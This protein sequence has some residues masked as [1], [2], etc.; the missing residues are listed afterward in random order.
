MWVVSPGSPYLVV[1]RT[2]IFAVALHRKVNGEKALLPI[3]NAEVNNM[4]FGATFP[5]ISVLFA[6]LFP[7]NTDA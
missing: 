4:N 2:F 7:A 5:H 6:E 3:Y 1:T